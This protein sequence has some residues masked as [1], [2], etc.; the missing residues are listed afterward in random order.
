MTD[1]KVMSGAVLPLERAARLVWGISLPGPALLASP[2]GSHQG[3]ALLGHDCLG[4]H[5]G[6][7]SHS[8]PGLVGSL[9]TASSHP[10]CCSA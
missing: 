4:G 8:M 3:Q 7:G 6:G 2:V 5:L 9:A 1:A 10:H